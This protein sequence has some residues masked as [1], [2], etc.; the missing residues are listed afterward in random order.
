MEFEF[1]WLL[2][3]PL[4]FA[5]GWLAA[6]IDIKQLLNESR[7]LPTAYYKGVNYLLNSQEELAINAFVEII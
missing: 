2:V 1:W 7:R 5:L 3:P 6:R 4:F